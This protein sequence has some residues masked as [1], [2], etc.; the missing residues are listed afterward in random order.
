MAA[1]EQRDDASQIQTAD[2]EAA[3]KSG[4]MP[5]RTAVPQQPQDTLIAEIIE[6]RSGRIRLISIW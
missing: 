3:V 6:M 1:Q 4:A 5:R 2:D